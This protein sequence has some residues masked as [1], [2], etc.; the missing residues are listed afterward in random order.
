MSQQSFGNQYG[1]VVSALDTAAS[2]WEAAA[3]VNFIHITSSDASCTTSTTGVVFNARRVTGANPDG[4]LAR[5]FFPST[6][7]TGR[8]LLIWDLS[9]GNISPYTLAG[10]L[11]H[12]LGH[13]L[14]FRHEQIRPEAGAGTHMS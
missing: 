8:E 7:R 1:A 14:G 12:E 11:K 2:A 5:S 6:D 4:I 10:V 13:V 9:F 3:N